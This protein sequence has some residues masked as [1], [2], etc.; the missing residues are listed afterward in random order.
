[1][2]LSCRG[3]GFEANAVTA[4]TISTWKELSDKLFTAD[5]KGEKVAA[6]LLTTWRLLSGT[7][8][9]IKAQFEDIRMLLDTI[10]R[11]NRAKRE[12]SGV[13][14]SRSG[15]RDHGA[16]PG[17]T[18]R[19]RQNERGAGVSAVH[20][21]DDRRRRLRREST[22]DGPGMNF[23][24]TMTEFH[25]KTFPAFHLNCAAGLRRAFVAVFTALGACAAVLSERARARARR[26]PRARRAAG[27]LCFPRTADSHGP[28]RCRFPSP[29]LQ[30]MFFP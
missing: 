28:K 26:R 15:T 30:R 10:I 14:G 4:F 8:E 2:L 1:M 16:G 6:S 27:G 29:S 19:P 23:T 11:R 9:D 3:Q 5:S 24:S 21:Q 7:V 12:S 18:E 20:I 25:L 22:A 13:K 17:T